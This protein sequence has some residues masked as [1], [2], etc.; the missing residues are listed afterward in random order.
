[1]TMD[2][3]WGLVTQVSPSVLVRIAGDTVDTP[4]AVKDSITLAT[5]DRVVLLLVGAQW[6]IA[7]KVVAT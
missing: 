6:W 2:V 4:I 3:T 5:N 1:V 7:G